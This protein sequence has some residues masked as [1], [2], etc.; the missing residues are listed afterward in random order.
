MGRLI[1][2]VA[3]TL[4]FGLVFL[5]GSK[6]NGVPEA[7]APLETIGIPA[8]F[9]PLVGWGELV[10]AL[11]LTHPPLHRIA[12]AAMA[13]WMLSAA[14]LHA[15]SLD[16][17]GASLPVGLATL[18]VLLFRVAPALRPSTAWPA[19]LRVLPATG[20]ARSIFVARHV[21]V[22]FLVRWAVGGVMFWAA[23]PLLAVSHALRMGTSDGKERLELVLLYLLFY[24]Y[25][26][27]GAWNFA[28]HFFAADMVAQSVGWAAGSPFQQELAFYALGTG[29]VGLLTPWVRDRFWVAAALAPSIFVYGAAFTH[30]EDH[31]V[32]GNDA[33]M[34]WS[35]T[36]VGANLLIP[37]AILALVWAY[38]RMGGFRVPP[39][40]TTA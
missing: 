28:G 29:V 36:A 23:L 31:F 34:N 10:L 26:V 40:S 39:G 17:A 13:A 32:S 24:G 12:G 1:R 30:I 8:R 25:G 35:F 11:L 2:G 7:M 6:L 33:P 18:G 37:T 5:G 21:A 27:G 38:A 9:W 4:G 20:M 22:A 15:A 19:P 16:L 3:V 14:V